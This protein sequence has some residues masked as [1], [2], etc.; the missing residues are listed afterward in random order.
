MSNS[1]SDKP[2]IDSPTMAEYNHI[3]KNSRTNSNQQQQQQQQ[4]KPTNLQLQPSTSNST[5]LSPYPT[6]R[7]ILVG[8]A[9]LTTPRW[10]NRSNQQQ[11]PP[12][13]STKSPL[14]T[15][16]N[17]WERNILKGYTD[18]HT[19]S[20]SDPLQ[21]TTNN[22]HNPAELANPL[23]SPTL[24]H[25]QHLS[26]LRVLNPNNEQQ[27]QQQPSSSASP[28]S[29]SSP[30]SSHELN[31]PNRSSRKLSVMK[32]IESLKDFKSSMNIFKGAAGKKQHDRMPSE[33]SC[34]QSNQPH[35]D[36][37]KHPRHQ[38]SKPEPIHH[39]QQQQQHHHHH[40]HHHTQ[41]NIASS[42]KPT[43]SNPLSSFSHH[44]SPST[45][46]HSILRS[47]SSGLVSTDLEDM[48]I[49]QV[50][51]QN[52]DTAEAL[53][54]LDGL[55]SPRATRHSL[56]D[57]NLSNP[58]HNRPTSTGP[59]RRSITSRSN[60]RPS[61]P[62]AASVKDRSAPKD[63]SKL[64]Q[65]PPSTTSLKKTR[66]RSI[67]S[68]KDSPV[69]FT[70][71]SYVLQ[72]DHPISPS[73]QRS[74]FQSSNTA[75][76][77]TAATTHSPSHLAHHQS[78]TSAH[79]PTKTV[80]GLSSASSSPRQVFH[81]IAPK[82]PHTKP[83]TQ[84]ELDGN[85]SSPKIALSS[86]S[87]PAIQ[88][89][90]KRG[91]SSSTSYT[92]GATTTT[93]ESRESTLATS[94]SSPSFPPHHHQQQHHHR[95][96]QSNTTV[97]SRSSPTK[98]RSSVGSE[99]SSVYS[100]NCPGADTGRHLERSNSSNLT[101]DTGE[102]ISSIPPVPPLPK[103]Y[104]TFKAQPQS[105]RPSHSSIQ[106]TNN[107]RTN[108][109]Q[110]D[111]LH[112]PHKLLPPEGASHDQREPFSPS[113]A[114]IDS[115]L[116]VNTP[117]SGASATSRFLHSLT[118]QKSP[119]DHIGSNLPSSHPSNLKQNKKWS[120]S[121]ALGM[122]KTGHSSR[123]SVHDD[124]HPIA[125]PVLSP[126]NS[127][128]QLCESREAVGGL[129]THT[130]RGSWLTGTH[131]PAPES[132]HSSAHNQSNRPE[133]S[134]HP[135]GQTDAS[136]N[137]KESGSSILT[138]DTTTTTA[139]FAVPAL[140]PS[141]GSG[142]SSRR[143]PSGIPF[144]SRKTSGNQ[145]V[146]LSDKSTT[147]LTES[148]ISHDSS[149]GGL[150]NNKATKALEKTQNEGEVQGRRSMMSLNVF[151]RNSVH[152][153]PTLSSSKIS[154]SSVSHPISS[155][156]ETAVGSKSASSRHSLK[157]MPA[158]SSPIRETHAPQSA[159]KKLSISILNGVNSET[160]ESHLNE[161]TSPKKSTLGSKASNLIGR[162]RG[163]TVSVTGSSKEKVAVPPPL[164]PL[165]MSAIHSTTT[166]R[167]ASITSPNNSFSSTASKR[168]S[169]DYPTSSSLSSRAPRVRTLKEST[170]SLRKG[171][172]TIDA[173]PLRME[174]ELSD[175]G[176]KSVINQQTAPVRQQKNAMSPAPKIQ[177]D[178]YYQASNTDSLGSPKR[179]EQAPASN[180]ENQEHSNDFG[181][182]TGHQP[183]TLN[184][185]RA[186][187]IQGSLI[188]RSRSGASNASK[189]LNRLSNNDLKAESNSSPTKPSMMSQANT[190][191]NEPESANED[192]ANAQQDTSA[193]A[194]LAAARRTVA[195]SQ[196]VQAARAA[197]RRLSTTHASVL[198][199]QST[200]SEFG[201]SASSGVVPSSRSSRT[202]ASKLTIPSR[203]SRSSTTPSMLS[204]SEAV[205]HSSRS[206]PGHGLRVRTTDSKGN[207]SPTI[208]EEE[209]K[210]DEEMAQYVARQ[211]SKK[212]MS[213]MTPAEV[214]K[215]F[216]FPKPN[217]PTQPMTTQ[218]AL[219]LYKNY[220]SDYEK[221][222][223]LGY[224]KI[225]YVGSESAK[226]MASEDKP[227]QN[228]GYDDERGDYQI[229]KNDHL[230]YRYE[231]V[232]VLGKGSFGQV[233]QCRD[234]RTGE[235]VAIKIIR[236]KRRFH[237]QALVEIR[238][239]EN[240]LSWDPE[241]KHCVLKM[242]D[243]FTFRGHLCIVNELLSINLYELIRNNSF[244]GFS[245]TL[246]RR[247][248]IQIL[249]SLSL[250]RHHRVVHCD[251]KP[252]NIL[253]KHPQK[254][255]IKTIDFGS[256]CF[257]NEKVYTY[258]QSRF[259][260]SPEV[261]LGMNY[262]MAIDMWS[263]GCILAELYT[264]YPIFPGETES[265]QLACIM[266]VLGMP[267]KYLVDRSSR[268]KLF[269]DSTGTP[270]PVVNSKGRRRRVGSKTLQSVLK[271]DDELF[272]D[273]IAKCLAWDPERRLK[274][275]PA[276]RHPW[277]LAGRARPAVAQLSASI[278]NLQQQ[279]QQQHTSGS[280]TSSS[281][282]NS[283]SARLAHGRFNS[284]SGSIHI[285][286]PRRKQVHLAS[287]T[288]SSAHTGS[289]GPSAPT[290]SQLPHLSAA[291]SG[292]SSS[293][294]TTTTTIGPG[295]NSVGY[296]NRTQS[297]STRQSL[298]TLHSH[299]QNH[300]HHHQPSSS[301]IHPSS[302]ASSST[303]TTTS[304]N[305]HLNLTGNGKLNPAASSSNSSSTTTTA[306]AAALN[307]NSNSNSNSSSSSAR[308]GHPHSL[309]RQSLPVR[310]GP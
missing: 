143:T 112:L 266:E 67:A 242:T 163:K 79:H 64:T 134:F 305:H 252:E 105:R 181:V 272:V 61:S 189:T 88:S 274:P 165:Q 17:N 85:S 78:L 155:P 121:A 35:H 123:D 300:H 151:I 72:S 174:E 264:G 43:Q 156:N 62:S 34:P 175:D 278:S 19:S 223:I 33:S 45:I 119:E 93:A 241:D 190:H 4:R 16:D 192:F 81:S 31:Q 238:V 57:P 299:Q 160:P 193:A 292:S 298:K 199:D 188:P 73:I 92:T 142:L 273:F 232:D 205:G 152:R 185:K 226:K 302:S 101:T 194:R 126:A 107:T 116:S 284:G 198:G 289:N 251:L 196:E 293:T 21:T 269:F 168:R 261:I 102:K 137:R 195:K 104:E 65:D 186:S 28:C 260:R 257:E 170:S 246:I 210:G 30:A 254:S 224:E 262:H 256:S 120:L 277:I 290:I 171:L 22:D 84:A 201:T 295:R 133:S 167:V 147:N 47:A 209:T 56:K 18:E 276:M 159:P 206:S 10:T 71:D 275:D 106:L 208:G 303:T 110:T 124:H 271:T 59:R 135:S 80:D 99:A 233:L 301:I 111:S 237:H 218:E 113:V 127:H 96:S 3:I 77:T 202:I 48:D 288:S 154:P 54:K 304:S 309:A 86:A 38:P 229:V 184:S 15:H 148:T 138:T 53:R 63:R 191:N 50:A 228:Y 197:S 239:L 173:S 153:R 2:L 166:N 20:T 66:T 114:T 89:N 296:R 6:D 23:T 227:A 281:S 115:Q 91:S 230:I 161:A 94:V 74:T 203:M 214:A 36:P 231:I 282:V 145:S 140:K 144:F 220:L 169:I 122:N 221:G 245:T 172:P 177:S 51:A 24:N 212:L 103:D 207:M 41:S 235:M 222:E 128:H 46:A 157:S 75:T 55:S 108:N 7:S 129:A 204:A 219:R 9:E 180:S 82:G 109:P 263:L 68:S 70:D 200:V 95:H 97:P 117:S 215:L 11:Q 76:T 83:T 225:Y 268:R 244:N 279:Q 69:T 211:R 183:V 297:S 5:P 253:L 29:S 182:L 60:S 40:H 179:R 149:N 291:N 32:S 270:R 26:R 213:G 125:H 306:A 164:P 176:S 285:S 100:N 136:R 255:A 131:H 308:V 248:T 58:H 310:A 162:R 39:H 87:S 286:S 8:L 258:I 14:D 13:Q 234:H 250:L 265:E 280:L 27:Q 146:N 216:E 12:P 52:D 267:D 307:S 236:N 178:D 259:Y 90:W 247:F 118:S 150:K 37:D 243:H 187:G 1:N 132:L 217:E 130:K 139:G 98:S 158:K 25:I 240:L 42:N 44:S 283:S 141:I 249:T 287:S 294:T 49:Q